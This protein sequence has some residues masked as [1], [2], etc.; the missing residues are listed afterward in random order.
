[1]M[2]VDVS[3]N[4]R[5]TLSTPRV[6]F[7][8]RYAVG[9]VTFANYDIAPDGQHFV[10]VKEESG[11][12]RLGMVLNWSDELKRLASPATISSPDGSP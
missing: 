3:A 11:A 1:V 6:L 4:P 5:L 12:G 9:T 8:Q 7:E 2:V 10:M